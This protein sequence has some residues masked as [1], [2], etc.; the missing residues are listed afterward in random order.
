MLKEFSQ[1]DHN[2]RGNVT[3]DNVVARKGEA[4]VTDNNPRCRNTTS[5][6]CSVVQLKTSLS[7]AIKP[8]VLAQPKYPTYCDGNFVFFPSIYEAL[9]L[10]TCLSVI[11]KVFSTA[12]VHK[13]NAN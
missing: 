12:K 10:V 7:S 5:D 2:H 9:H 11:L 4:R 1:P 6:K 8:G 3:V 13:Y